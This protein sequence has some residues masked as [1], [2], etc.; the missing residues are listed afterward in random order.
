M[1]PNLFARRGVNFRTPN[2]SRNYRKVFSWSRVRQ[3][4]AH[5]G[6]LIFYLT[7]KE[8]QFRPLKYDVM[9]GVENATATILE[10]VELPKS[11]PAFVLLALL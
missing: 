8:I 5:R 7:A 10:L 4:A 3:T 1:R 6:S 9:E 2:L 11:Y